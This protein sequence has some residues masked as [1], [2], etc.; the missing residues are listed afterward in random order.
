MSV[1]PGWQG[2]TRRDRLPGNW[3][4]LRRLVQQRAGGRCENV[5]DGQ[6]CQSTGSHCDHI[7]PGDNHSVANLQW[8]CPPCHLSKSGREGAVARPSLYRRAERHPGLRQKPAAP[9]SL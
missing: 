5:I 8:L 9:P 6:R 4:Q 3:R 7:D 2:S 1:V